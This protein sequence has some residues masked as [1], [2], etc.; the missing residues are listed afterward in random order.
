MRIVITGGSGLIGQAL[1]N[2]LVKNGHEVTILT[3]NPEKTRLTLPEAKAVYWDG[4]TQGDWAGSFEGAEAVVNL[5]GASI[6][7]ENILKMRWTPA[8]K[9]AILES[10]VNAGAAVTEAIQAA[11]EKPKVLVQSSAIGYYGPQGDQ[12]IDEKAP[13][14]ED[15]LAGVCRDWEDSTKAVEA[16]GVRRVVARTGLVFSRGSL[17]FSL[18]KLPFTFFVGGPLGSGK[19]V[20]SWIHIEDMVAALQFLIENPRAQG[21]YN[22]TAPNPVSNKAFSKALGKA[23]KRP[24]FIPVPS[25]AM[26]LALGEV[27]TL[28]L[29][30]QRVIPARLLEAGYAFKF[31][32]LEEA[33]A[34]LTQPHL[35]FRHSFRVNAPLEEVVA[36]HR[37]TSIL[38]AI[39][40]LPIIVQFKRVEGVGEGT[41]ADFNLWFGPIPVHWVARHHDVDPTN[42]FW[43]TQVEGPFT[44]WVHQHRFIE[45][46][47]GKVQVIDDIQAQFGSGL[48]SGLVSRFMWWT[49][50]ILFAY[51]GW[52]TK[53]L[54]E[55]KIRK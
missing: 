23:M 4:R 54:I 49:L 1:T 15:Y 41:T 28:A 14:A 36:F 53:R 25:F 42:G 51:R 20:F 33:L 6:A 50:P 44:K 12:P 27:S 22:L 5:A 38:K 48:F 32:R 2:E 43:D 8:R 46:G 47:K 9:K 35:R 31:K 45:T 24:A 55:R 39:T 30:G 13:N 11:K 26:K 17:I 10:R 16:L 3:R 18:L 52:Q 34:K 37:D 19:Q 29:E 21:V 40:P 7:G